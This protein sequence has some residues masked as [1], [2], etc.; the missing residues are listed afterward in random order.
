M[1]LGWLNSYCIYLGLH[2]QDVNTEVHENLETKTEDIEIT[3][4]NIGYGKTEYSCPICKK[5]YKG[6]HTFIKS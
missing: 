4:E 1:F 2:E 5:T 3:I 6:R